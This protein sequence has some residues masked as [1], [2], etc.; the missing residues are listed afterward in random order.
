MVFSLQVGASTHDQTM[1]FIFIDFGLEK[2]K[3]YWMG[4]LQQSGR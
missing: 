3:K 2:D 1:L 4:I